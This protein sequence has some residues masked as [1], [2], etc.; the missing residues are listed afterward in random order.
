MS[1]HREKLVL[2]SINLVAGG[3]VIGS[4]FQG[5][6]SHTENKAA[7]WGNIPSSL[8]PFYTISMATA[9]VGYLIFTSYFI[10]L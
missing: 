1:I 9:A 3:S 6:M 8:L 7:L 5:L 10:F 4:Y 2:L